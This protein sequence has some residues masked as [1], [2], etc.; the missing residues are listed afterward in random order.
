MHQLSPYVGKLKTGIASTLIRLYSNA[1]DVVMDPFCGSGVVPLESALLNRKACANDLSP[2]AYVLT[3][4]KLESPRRGAAAIKKAERL[5]GEVAAT[6]RSVDLRRVPRWV[7]KFFHPETLREVI[8]AAAILREA[9]DYF[10]LSCVLGILHHQRPGFLSYP[11]SHLVPYLRDKKYPRETYPEM[12]GYRDLRSRLLAKVRRAYRNHDPACMLPRR[13]HKVW[14]TNAM[15][16][17]CKDSSVDA[18]ISS[19]PYYK[20]L[21]YARDNRLRLWFLGY[22]DWKELDAKLTTDPRVYLSQM[23]TCL[24]EMHRILRPGKHCVLVLG[25]VTTSSRTI[26]TAEVVSELAREATNGGFVIET[27]HQDY[28]PE[29]RRS[30][31]GTKT[32]K[33]DR[34]LV[35]R[36]R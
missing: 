24:A 33:C 29:E 35:M 17:P 16:L 27:I 31:R 12:Y 23:S 5:L 15:S 13:Y 11:A 28:I 26:R 4:G 20:A 36:K 2:Y 30:R 19:P 14:Q 18:I 6:R 10:L 8:A 9:R 7:R 21:D 1:Q 32:T 3:R 22:R 25:D 34:M